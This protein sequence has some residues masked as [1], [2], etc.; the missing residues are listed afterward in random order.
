MNYFVLSCKDL[1]ALFD[2]SKHLVNLKRIYESLLRKNQVTVSE[3]EIGFE[4]FKAKPLEFNVSEQYLKAEIFSQAASMFYDHIKIDDYDKEIPM[5]FKNFSH[6]FVEPE[7]T[8]SRAN[9]TDSSFRSIDGRGNNLRRNAMGSSFTSFG[10]LLKAQY[11]DNIHSIRKSIRGYKL[12]S[13][14]NIVRKL[15]LND[16][17]HLNKFQKR[18][19]IP[20]MAAVMFGQY[21]AYDVG[22]SQ[23]TQYNDGADGEASSCP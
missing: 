11:N 5:A 14:R 13:A 6:C 8:R 18:V 3:N 19:K 15:F 2:E 21:I 22:S 1:H 23:T 4:F 16:E 20:N 17:V 9:L 7:D 10:R 12:P